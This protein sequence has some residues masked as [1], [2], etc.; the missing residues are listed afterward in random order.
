M[1]IYTHYI[2]YIQVTSEFTLL[3]YFLNLFIIMSDNL[4]TMGSRGLRILG[5]RS[6]IGV[7]RKGK[8]C[9]TRSYKKFAT[10]YRKDN[11]EY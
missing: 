11:L 9:I 4:S 6:R 8:K 3:S 10:D 1:H 2:T 5:E 7:Q